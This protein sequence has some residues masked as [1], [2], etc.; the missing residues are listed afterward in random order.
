MPR[1]LEVAEVVREAI[2]DG[3]ARGLSASLTLPA[4]GVVGGVAVRVEVRHLRRGDLALTLTAPSGRQAQLFAGDSRD[5]RRDVTGVLGRLA[6]DRFRGEP[7][8]GTWT[9]T[10]VDRRAGARGSLIGWALVA[11][12]QPETQAQAPRP[13]VLGQPTAAPRAL[14]S[15]A[16]SAA[17]R[18]VRA[19]LTA[20][21][22][23]E[24]PGLLAHVRALLA[25]LRPGLPE[26]GA[27]LLEGLPTR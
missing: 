13:Q 14:E 26:S 20:A 3:H 19:R 7:L 9:L 18:W 15:E 12:A 21:L 1:E 2:P 8:G 10:V 22:E 6:L 5:E 23:G 24:A 27:R 17:S 16:R 4:Q 25:Y 11:T